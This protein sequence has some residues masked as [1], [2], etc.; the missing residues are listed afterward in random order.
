Y[1]PEDFRAFV[2][3]HHSPSAYARLIADR[4]HAVWL[5]TDRDGAGVG[6]ACAGPC[7][8]P[9]PD[10]PENAGELLRLYLLRETQGHGVGARLLKT[11]LAWL[12]ARFSD[13]YLS[14]YAENHG[15]Q[16]LYARFG[17]EKVHDYFFMVGSH[18]DPEFILKRRA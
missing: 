13:I 15:A 9:V 17:F 6:Y 12:D 10:D 8:L 16:R 7:N 3:K 1:R 11:A 2:D 5:A 18:A 14:V 4:E